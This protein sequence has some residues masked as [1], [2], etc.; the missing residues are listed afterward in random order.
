MN[1]DAA[2]LRG[3]VDEGSEV[4][5]TELVGRHVD[6]VYGAALRRTRDPHRAADVAQQVFT[7]LAREARKLSQHTVLA[8]WLHTATRNAA[9]NLMISEHRRQV[10][11]SEALTLETVAGGP[12]PDWERLRPLLDAAIDELPEADRAAVVL[13]FLERRPFAEIGAALRMTEDAARMRTDRALDKLR[14]ALA[15]RGITSSAAALA[16][17]VSG[18]PLVSAPAGLAATLATQALALASNGSL[19]AILAAFMTTKV[20]GVAAL[21]ALVSFGTAVYVGFRYD[22]NIAT[23]SPPVPA[24]VKRDEFL[25]DSRKP[26]A[27]PDGTVQGTATPPKPVPTAIGSFEDLTFG[28][29]I[30]GG[31]VLRFRPGPS[32]PAEARKAVRAANG[33]AF[34]RYYAALYKKLAFTQEQIDRLRELHLIII[35]ARRNNLNEMRQAHPELND[36]QSTQAAVQE[37]VESAYEVFLD[38]VTREFGKDVAIQVRDYQANGRKI[39]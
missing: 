6:L 15:G 39:Q 27:D 25:A 11:E 24:P 37:I 36:R 3:Y 20:I 38:E 35:D 31:G 34:D 8:A 28:I 1:D 19:A 5:F 7:K 26:D 32:D 29:P 2:L 23:V 21:V 17:V 9:L 30:E 16:V 22:G 13:R 10:R 33:E 18:Q 12:M 14:L 4:A